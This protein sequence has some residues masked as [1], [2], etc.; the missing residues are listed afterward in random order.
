MRTDTS[1]A[2]ELIEVINRSVQVEGSPSEIRLKHRWLGE[3][4][5][6]HHFFWSIIV[7]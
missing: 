6:F 3:P 7:Q 1:L 2:S 5:H 4:E